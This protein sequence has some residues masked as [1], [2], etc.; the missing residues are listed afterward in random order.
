MIRFRSHRLSGSIAAIALLPLL[1]GSSSGALTTV[2]VVSDGYVPSI[3][4]A[5]VGQTTRADVDTGALYTILDSQFVRTLSLRTID[6]TSI[7][8]AGSGTVKA[9][10]L[11]PVSI[12]IGAQAFLTE[13][14]IALDLS[15]V[16][17]V[18]GERALLGYDFFKHFVVNIDYAQKS[19][20]L[21]DPTAFRYLGLVRNRIPLIV[22]PP[23][24]YVRALIGAQGVALETH[25]LRVDTGSSD[26]VDDDIIL[27]STGSKT[28]VTAGIG[29]G[30]SFKST[31][32]VVSVLKIGPYTLHNLP[33]AS[34]GVQLIGSGVWRR[35]NVTFDIPHRYMYLEEP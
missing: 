26:A 19:I 6:T 22:R 5:I 27:R 21:Y 32:G 10:R 2:A 9:L 12:R 13:H 24:I 20:T 30:K 3:Q 25:L 18:V 35:F 15:N 17:S 8:G 33:S 34:G 4:I 1:L 28:S 7:G 23:R 16:G 31:L 29:I 14:P 11:E